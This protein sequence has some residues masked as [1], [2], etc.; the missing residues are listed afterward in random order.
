MYVTLCVLHMMVLLLV[1]AVFTCH[2]DAVIKVMG[3]NMTDVSYNMLFLRYGVAQ[4]K[5]TSTVI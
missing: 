5:H 3:Y 4:L 2:L 1:S